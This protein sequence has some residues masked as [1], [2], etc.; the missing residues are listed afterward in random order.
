MDLYHPEGK[1]E[2][3]GG[4]V[5]GCGGASGGELVC[6]GQG[7][8]MAGAPTAIGGTK[9]CP[10]YTRRQMW[11]GRLMIALLQCFM[12]ILLS[13]VSHDLVDPLHCLHQLLL[14]QSDMCLSGLFP[15]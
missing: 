9:V 2:G 11:Q 10:A 5:V 7:A 1:G 4:E 8:T 14:R 6:S 3:G 15:G 12:Q 13:R